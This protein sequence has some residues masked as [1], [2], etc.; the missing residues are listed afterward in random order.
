M[1]KEG[2]II[3]GPFWPEP[4]KVN[5]VDERAG[6]FR[7]VGATLFS[8]KH[9]DLILTKEDIEQVK[10]CEFNLDFTASGTEAFLFIEATRFR[11]ASNFDPLL[12][13]STSKIDP[14]P[15]QIE[16]VYGYILKLPLIR[17]L[18][19]DDPGAGKTIMAGLIIKE[20]KLRGLVNRILIIVPGHL[21]DQWRRELKDKFQESFT[22]IDKSLVDSLYGENPW[23]KENQVITSTDFAKREEIR[24]ALKG[25]NWD[26]V[27]VDEA[28]KMAAYKYGD[29]LSKTARYKLGEVISERTTH[30]LFLTAT[31]HKGDPENYRLFLDLLV[32]GFFATQELIEESLKNKDNPLFIRRLKEDL[33]DF[34]GKPIF[35]NRNPQT[36]KFSLSEKEKRLYNKLSEYVISQYNKALELDK[37]R[38]V[39][40]ALLILQRRM[41]SSTYALL[42]SLERR[43][44]KLEE[45]L[46]RTKLA[47]ED[48]NDID[49]DIDE[50]DDYEEEERWKQE[51]KWETLSIAKNKEELGK[52][53]AV[54]NDLITKAKEI[55]NE[56]QEVKLK[57]LKEAIEKGFQQIKEMKGNE[58]I[59]IFTESKD[60]LEYLSKKIEQWGYSVTCIHGGMN[61][62]A[63]IDA[64]NEFKNSKQV[65]VATEA[66]GEGINLQFCHIMINYDIPWNPNRLE[67]RM[68]RIHRYGQ[69]KDVYIF[70]LI[71]EDTREGQILS[72]IFDKLEEVRNALGSDKVFDV[73]GEVFQGKNLYQLI[74]EAVANAKTIDEI[75][76]ELDIRVDEEYLKKIR[77]S[78]GESLATRHIDYT[79]IK[80]MAEKAKEYRLIPEYVEEFF[81]KAFQKAGGR[82]KIGKDKFITIDSVPY[83]LRKIAEEVD[84]KNRYGK[85]LHG[86]TKATFDKEIA[87]KNSEAEFIS[88]G[89]P[90]LEALLEWIDRNYFGSLQKGAVFEDPEGKYNGTFWFFEGEVKDGRGN[91]AGK[92]LLAIYDN[93]VELKGVNPAVLWDFVPIDNSSTFTSPIP[94]KEKALD[95]A[96]N[97]IE[98]YKNEILEERK[99]QGEIKKKY[100]IRS[101]EHIIEKLDLELIQLI[102]RKK[103]GENVDIAIINKEERKKHYENAKK[104]LQIE[105]EQEISLSCSMP[106]FLGAILVRPSSSTEMVSDEEI[107]KIGME[108][109]INY[110]RSQ[111][112]FPFDVSKENLGYDIKSKSEGEIRYI[113]VKARKD[114]GQIV[115]T[116]NEWLKAKRF[117]EQYWLYVV[118]N[119]VKNPTLYIINNPAENLNV[120]EKVE[121]VRFIVP[122]EE[123]KNKG[124]KV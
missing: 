52:E 95:Y 29:K 1:I 77:E 69:Q 55:I 53:I 71:A 47:K 2:M 36:I 65:M 63:R 64:E 93:G 75:Y 58:K 89:H 49:I 15:F 45:L 24:P 10:I 51:N 70:N 94:N 68:G 96:I 97:L 22:V 88:F 40:F 104:K 118:S 17:F 102:E 25:V 80:E 116:P 41:A 107:E 20:L 112:R 42:K 66:A 38:N 117:K 120:Q 26:L 6:R 73:I 33:K 48:Q 44:E 60:T 87:F 109:A 90:L 31:P 92:R 100:G 111:G 14:L 62:E 11:F 37:K 79:R 21:K 110:E 59:L 86:Y 103:K 85:L 91:V 23:Q 113:E 9:E 67:Q 13:M 57:E 84:F 12:A 74:L 115:L 35:T 27:I 18:I 16:A 83:D 101:L 39:A 98:N 78:L 82:F 61:L 81:K 121:I 32:P 46:K 108:I 5:R 106:K 114:E 56:E 122:F 54:L 72:R 99:R 50:V 3:E 34:E 124:E 19:A 30:L 76:K 105:I 123:W 28:H 43:K 8:N 7:I 119:A 4:V